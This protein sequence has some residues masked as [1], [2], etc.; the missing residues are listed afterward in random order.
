MAPPS[1]SP[2]TMCESDSPEGEGDHVATRDV[3][4]GP[5][6][7]IHQ[8]LA[9]RAPSVSALTAPIHLPRFT[10]QEKMTQ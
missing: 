1:A 9:S 4:E 6:G 2:I 3:V 10:G 8:Q 7:P 5:H